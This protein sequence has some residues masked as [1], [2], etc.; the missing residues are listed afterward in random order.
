MCT[1]DDRIVLSYHDSLLKQSDVDLL[2]G[3]HWLNDQI[4][5]FFFE[6]LTR[7]VYK[8]NE[9]LLFVSPEVT[10]CLKM[11]SP[12]EV[13]MFLGPVNATEKS[14][15]FFA[16]NDQSQ[17]AAGGSHWSLLVWCKSQGTFYHYDSSTPSNHHVA[18]EMALKLRGFLGHPNAMV[19]G[20]KCLQQANSYDCGVHLIAQAEFLAKQFTKSQDCNLE[21]P[22]LIQRQLVTHKREEI[23]SLIEEL[24][25]GNK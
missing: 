4:I 15:I 14:I 1:T 24:A 6:Y 22:K 17:N 25:E 3:P 11:V 10:Q 13:E 8:T 21:S 18:E 2:T 19:K 9:S 16:L 23:V 12:E 5:S 20:G 7:D